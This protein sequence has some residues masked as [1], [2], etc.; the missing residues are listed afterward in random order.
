MYLGHLTYLLKSRFGRI[1]PPVA[2]ELIE[3][4]LMQELKAWGISIKWIG[5]TWHKLCRKKVVKATIPTC[6]NLQKT[7]LILF[8]SSMEVCNQKPLYPFWNH[9]ILHTQFQRITSNV[10]KPLYPTMHH[11]TIDSK[12]HQIMRPHVY[13]YTNMLQNMQSW[14]TRED[15]LYGTTSSCKKVETLH[16]K[17]AS[18]S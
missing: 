1:S 4:C 18:S 10:I 8:N 17:F 5:D 7:G 2:R 9:L 16:R 15:S 6:F 13:R 11:E 14:P 12:T 3:L